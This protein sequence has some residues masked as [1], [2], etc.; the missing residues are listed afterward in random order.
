ME[1]FVY[2]NG[3]FISLVDDDNPNSTY[4]I[5]FAQCDTPEKIQHMV[6]HLEDKQW[7]YSAM[8]ERFVELACDVNDIDPEEI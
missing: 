6:D 1:E 4:D 8:I 2:V 5:S 3:Q 7:T